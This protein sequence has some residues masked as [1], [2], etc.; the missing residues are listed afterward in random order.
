MRQRRARYVE[1]AEDVGLVCAIELLVG[2]VRKL[3]LIVLFRG[4]VHQYVETAELADYLLDELLADLAV[5]D[6]TRHGK[7]LAALVPDQPLRLGGILFLVL[8]EKGDLRAFARKQHGRR[9]PDAGVS[10]RDGRDLTGEPA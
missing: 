8:V 9:P 3:L 7:G 5:S 2:N 1:H 10:A 6:I 4:V